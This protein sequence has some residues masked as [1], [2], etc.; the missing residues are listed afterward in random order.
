[1][2]RLGFLLKWSILMLIAG[3]VAWTFAGFFAGH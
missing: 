1:M 3:L 2:R